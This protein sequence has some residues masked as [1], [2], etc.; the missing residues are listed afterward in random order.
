MCGFFRCEIGFLLAFG[1]DC[2]MLGFGNDFCES[3][4]FD[5]LVVFCLGLC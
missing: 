3:G 4:R 2:F 1:E 5:V